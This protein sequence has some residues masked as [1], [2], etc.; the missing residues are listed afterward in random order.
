MHTGLRLAFMALCLGIMAYTLD[1]SHIRQSLSAPSPAWLLLALLLTL[2]QVFLSAWRWQLTTHALGLSLSLRRAVSEYYIATFLN[3]LLPGGVGGDVARAWR[4]GHR[5]ASRT[6]AFHAVMIER[7][8]G[9][10]ALLLIAGIMLATHPVV[11][12][13]FHR[14]EPSGTTGQILLA[15]LAGI[16]SLLLFRTSTR[17]ALARFGHHIALSLCGSHLW[18]KQLSGSLVI[19][20]TYIG[21]Y[22]CCARALGSTLDSLTLLALIPPVLMAMALPLSIGG[23]GVREGAAA[24]IWASAGLSSSEGVAISVAYGATVLVSSLPGAIVMLMGRQNTPPHQQTSSHRAGEAAVE[25][26]I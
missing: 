22:A 21:A 25:Q 4:H 1:I 9:Q 14:S 7:A 3:Q 16:G 11:L 19:V 20:A 23:W 26:D 13:S 2:P 18:I 5:Q 8:S 17:K 15:G 24:L 10:L 12:T 6:R